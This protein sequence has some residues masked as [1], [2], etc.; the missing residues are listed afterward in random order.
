[1]TDAHS[2]MHIMSATTGSHCSQ[3]LVC[4]VFA[5]LSQKLVVPVGTL[6]THIF[7]SNAWIIKT[8]HITHLA[9]ILQLPLVAANMNLVLECK[10]NLFQFA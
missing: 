5:I 2:G 10:R 8:V 6:V 1:M 9:M 4:R 3:W 7:H